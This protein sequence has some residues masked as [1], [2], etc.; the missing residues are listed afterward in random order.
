MTTIVAY[1]RVSTE[2]QAET[3]VSLDAQ[4][5]KLELYAELHDLEL[6][7]IEVDAGLS[8]KTLRRP[9]LQ[10]ALGRL[11]AGEAT[12]LLVCKLDRLTRSVRDMGELVERY[13]ASRFDL[14]SVADAIDTR[15]AGGRLVLNVLVSVAQ[16]EREANGERTSA[17]LQHLRAQGVAMGRAPY[18][19]RYSEPDESGRRRLVEVEGEIEAIGRMQRLSAVGLSYAAVAAVLNDDSVPTKLG[20]TWK[21]NTVR[22]ILLRAA[23]AD[24]TSEAA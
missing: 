23:E 15:S 24:E 3:G 2:E 16:W 12:G 17:A 14:L 5:R 10:R 11:D 9:G 7:S 13:F 4:R 18:G 19:F 20:G 8:A 22:R 1:I 6:V 21:A